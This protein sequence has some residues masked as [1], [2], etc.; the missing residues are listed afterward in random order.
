M[1]LTAEACVRISYNPSLI[2]DSE[3]GVL[4]MMIRTVDEYRVYI[5]RPDSAKSRGPKG[6][7]KYYEVAFRSAATATHEVQHKKGS[8]GGNSGDRDPSR[9]RGKTPV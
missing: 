2:G 8:H 4:A 5:S 1:V 7:S 9:G 3:I 6:A